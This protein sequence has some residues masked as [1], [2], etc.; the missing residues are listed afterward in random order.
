MQCPNCSL[1]KSNRVDAEDPESGERVPL[2]NPL[3]EVWRVRF[4]LTSSGTVLGRTPGGRASV[5]ALG[6]NLP[7]ARIARALQLALGLLKTE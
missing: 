4:E 2:F 7:N 3:T 1:H 6:M 5:V